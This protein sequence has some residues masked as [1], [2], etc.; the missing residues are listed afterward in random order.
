MMQIIGG[1]ARSQGNS[2]KCSTNASIFIKGGSLISAAKL[3]SGLQMS[4]PERLL[5]KA[6]ERIFLI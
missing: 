6:W 2:I 5:F 3:P 4:L 1:K